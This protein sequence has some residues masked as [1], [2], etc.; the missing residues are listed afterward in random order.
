[1]PRHFTWVLADIRIIFATSGLRS[2]SYGF[3]SILLGLYL[4]KEGFTAP[5]V[6]AILAVMQVGG[7]ALTL[8]VS[9][10]ADRWGR[11][12]SL[13]ALSLLS[14]AGG[15]ALGLVGGFWAIM[16]VAA[17][18]NLTATARDRGSFSSLEQAMLAEASSPRHRN[19]TF[20]YYNALASL[21][22]AL[23]NLSSGIPILLALLLPALGDRDPIRVMFFLYAGIAALTAGLYT[24]LT[25]ATEAPQQGRYTLLVPGPSR[26]IVFKLAGLYAIDALGGGFIVH[27]FLAYWFSVR[28]GLELGSLGAVF[29]AAGLLNTFSQVAAAWLANR[30]GLLKTMVL[31]HIPSSLFLIGAALAPSAWLAVALYLG[32]E[33]LSQMDVPTRQSY[34]VAVVAPE[35]RTAAAGITTLSRNGASSIGPYLAG[36]TTGALSLAAPLLL[37]AGIK[38]VYDLLVY[39]TFRGVRPPDE[40][41]LAGAGMKA[42]GEEHPHRR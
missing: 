23:G 32:R 13:V 38:I 31:T 22:S 37:G 26:V 3:F 25:P 16:A 9:L 28:W 12:R 24:R 11:R 34:T 7:A 19:M 8:L 20:G 29:F 40:A 6:G 14:I 36:L 30:V 39:V 2:Y 10:L 17:L 1:M 15:I 27:S 35:A 18:G 33:A 41:A 42:P 21:A 4:G 5:Q